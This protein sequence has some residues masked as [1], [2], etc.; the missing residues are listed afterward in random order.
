MP[1]SS[2]RLTC[3]MA[4]TEAAAVPLPPL[5]LLGLLSLVAD[6]Y[7]SGRRGFDVT[8]GLVLLRAAA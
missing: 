2:L 3:D 7:G 1:P 6:N 4:W 8:V 5:T